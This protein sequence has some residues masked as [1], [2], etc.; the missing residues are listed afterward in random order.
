MVIEVPQP[1]GNPA[2]QEP[3]SPNVKPSPKR[4]RYERF[5][6]VIRYL[7]M[8]E[9]AQFF[10][11]IEDYRHKL[12]FRMIYELG[13]R[14]GEFVRI[15][16]LHLSFTRSTVFFP[17]ENT[18][19]RQRRASHL[20]LG[21]LNEVKSVLRAEGRMAKRSDRIYKPEEYLFYPRTPRA[22]Y[23]ENRIRQLFLRYA[24]LARLDRTYGRDT[25]GRLLHEF[26]VHSLRHS[27]IMNYVHVFKLPL[28]IVQK[29]V[30]HKSL[31]TTSIYLR[32][33]DEQVGQA[34]TEARA[35]HGPKALKTLGTLSF[36][37]DTRT[38]KRPPVGA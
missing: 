38:H 35:E 30:G 22:P 34:Y 8:E 29:Q 26:T 23:C 17:A 2:P 3:I 33:S 27:H 20:P 6:E 10:D 16:L 15:Q 18:K 25:Q 19:T 14:V 31:R 7:T 1:Q 24:R 28:P 4:P 36:Y 12:M 37:N 32:P 13:C 9:L 5:G 11:S 21:V